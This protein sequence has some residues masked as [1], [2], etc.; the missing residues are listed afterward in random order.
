ML[1]EL[2]AQESQVPKLMRTVAF[3][4]EPSLVQR[5]LQVSRSRI[6]RRMVR[7]TAECFRLAVRTPL[8][9]MGPEDVCND[10]RV[11]DQQATTIRRYRAEKY[12]DS[13]RVT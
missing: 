4:A 2:T 6:R 10:G 7:R 8:N 1:S 5:V 9:I 11:L 12:C 13:G 3:L